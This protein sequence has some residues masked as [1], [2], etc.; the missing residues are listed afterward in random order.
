M[1]LLNL[2]LPF[3]LHIPSTSMWTNLA[4]EGE[5]AIR[6]LDTDIQD[7]YR[8]LATR[9]LRQLIKSNAHNSTHKRL[10]YIL[11]NIKQKLTHNN[12]TVAR[13]DNGKTTVSIYSH[14]YNNKTTSFLGH[15]NFHILP[16]DPTKKYQA[17]I[18]KVLQQSNLIVNRHK[19]NS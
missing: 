6:L 1:D 8:N 2:G 15:N 19:K 3:S 9:K 11:K 7:T 13:A 4:M 17:N 18:I 16:N 12:A 14:H 10:K 5:Q